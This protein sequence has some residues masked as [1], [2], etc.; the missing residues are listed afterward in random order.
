MLGA[1]LYWEQI[2]RLFMQIAQGAYLHLFM[3][4]KHLCE[5]SLGYSTEKNKQQSQL[6]I[7]LPGGVLVFFLFT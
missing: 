2:P 4:C 6:Q 1:W 7:R 5:F 3:F